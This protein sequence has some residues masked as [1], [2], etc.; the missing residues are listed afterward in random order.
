MPST[1]SRELR[2]HGGARARLALL[3]ALLPAAMAQAHTQSASYGSIVITGD[4]LEY[5]IRIPEAELDAGVRLDTNSDG[6]VTAAEVTALSTLLYDYLER[7]LSL[8]VQGAGGLSRI[9]ARMDPP[10]A[11]VACWPSPT[12]EDQALLRVTLVYRIPDGARELVLR[13]DLPATTAT[14][15]HA[16]F[17]K[18]SQG[19]GFDPSIPG[20]SSQIVL[21]EGEEFRF[22]L[23]EPPGKAMPGVP[24]P[25]EYGPPGPEAPADPLWQFFRLGVEHIWTGYDHLLFLAALIVVAPGVL[26]LLKIATAFTVSHSVALALAVFGVVRLTGS[27]VEPAIAL[28]IVYVA[29]E[30]YRPV[31]TSRR[32]KVALVLGLIH[33]LGFADALR[34]MELTRSS[35]AACVLSFNLGVEAGQVVV[36][37]A[38]FPLLAWARRGRP[39]ASFRSFVRVASSAIAVVG[40]FWFVERAFHLG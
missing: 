28:T 9:D 14:P 31:K 32:W 15:D 13:S 12:A 21:K 29:L 10:S 30:N 35:L 19:S 40:L 37:A 23:K 5:G 1:S 38:L 7:A 11:S 39:D 27:I 36:L 3:L 17:V 22:P 34:E 4:R 33:G 2:P 26:D 25:P 16:H 8:R 20:H 24:V 18:L 6:T